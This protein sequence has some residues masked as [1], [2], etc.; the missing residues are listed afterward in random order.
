VLRTRSSEFMVR[1]RM[2]R[3]SSTLAPA[4]LKRQEIVKNSTD[5][6]IFISLWKYRG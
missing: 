4:A 3:V 6:R 1:P 2:T 5:R